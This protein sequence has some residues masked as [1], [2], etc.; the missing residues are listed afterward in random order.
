MFLIR[1]QIFQKKDRLIEK[2]KTYAHEQ[3][4]TAA[5]SIS[6]KLR[7]KIIN[8]D[9]ILT[10][11]CS[12]LIRRSLVEAWKESEL[13]FRVIVVDSGPDFEG[14]QMLESLTMQGINCTY[15]MINSRKNLKVEQTKHLKF[16]T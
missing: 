11:G 7:E 10:F 3:I 8:D 5:I 14:Q 13:K 1:N 15:V 9:I 4:E 2:I 12:S 16:Y 6:L